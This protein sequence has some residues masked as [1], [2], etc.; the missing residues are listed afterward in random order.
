MSCTCEKKKKSSVTSSKKKKTN[1][2]NKHL[3]SVNWGQNIV[4]VY[5][6][7]LYFKKKKQ[8]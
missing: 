3:L 2:D 8:P 6:A 4:I 7:V 1:L 5:L